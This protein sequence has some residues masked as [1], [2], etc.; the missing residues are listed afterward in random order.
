M[1]VS[2]STSAAVGI[3]FGTVYRTEKGYL[4][5]L[6][7]VEGRDVNRELGSSVPFPDEKEI[8]IPGGIKSKDIL[9]VT[10]L[11]ADGSYVGY[12]IPNPKAG[13]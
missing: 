12:S 4:Y 8:A 3:D 11:N 1:F 5:T 9:G 6:R 2:T 10:P 7:R 13:K